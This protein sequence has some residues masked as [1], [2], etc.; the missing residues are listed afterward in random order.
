M[1]K[2]K[3]NIKNKFAKDFVSNDVKKEASDVIVDLFVKLLPQASCDQYRQV[4]NAFEAEEFK[5]IATDAERC[6]M[7]MLPKLIVQDRNDDMIKLIGLIRRSACLC[8]WGNNKKSYK[9]Y[10]VCFVDFLE[11]FINST[12]KNKKE[13]INKIK[14]NFKLPPLTDE[15]EDYLATAFN[16][17]QVFLHDKLQ[18]KFKARLRRQDRTSGDKIWLPLG[19]IAKIFKHNKRTSYFSEWLD[20]L[21]DGIYIHYKDEKRDKI[22]SVSFSSDVFLDFQKNNDG[23]YDVYVIWSKVQA[24]K[25][26]RVYTPTGKGNK[27]EPMTV[28][29]ISEI[30]IDH[31]KPIDKTL[32]EL[33][34]RGKLPT[35]KAVSDVYKQLL[36]EITNQEK[37]D[38]EKKAIENIS[39]RSVF[40]IDNLLEE[41][42]LIG[43]DGLLRLM[44]SSF[45]EQKGNESTFDPIIVI[46][47]VSGSEYLGIMMDDV[48]LED[49]DGNDQKI[50]IYQRL[51]DNGVTRAKA[52]EAMP[53]GRKVNIT[54]KIIDLI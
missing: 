5:E 14:G 34:D 15:E 36:E 39:N 23:Q 7:T 30:D 25:R 2:N 41:L 22:T 13:I 46:K 27:K 16:S 51:S 53:K 20:M 19:F 8:T 4:V 28:K 12:S 47:T 31:I 38:L 37:A 49:K 18:A 54:K 40:S 32:R 6:F 33:G 26:Y 17:R 3:W 43:K 50:V 52:K 48:L 44:D 29:D 1:S 10:I 11:K 21:V 42:R 45:N 35:L 9:T 24:P